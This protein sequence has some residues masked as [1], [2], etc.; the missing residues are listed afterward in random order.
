M[1]ILF[2]SNSYPE[3]LRNRLSANSKVG[4]NNAVNTFQSAFIK[5]L[6][7]NNANFEVLCFPSLGTF[8]I[9]YKKMRVSGGDYIFEG[10]KIGESISYCALPILKNISIRRKIYKLLKNKIVTTNETLVVVTYN[11]SSYIIE[12]LTKLKRQYPQLIICPIVTDLIDE[13]FNPIYHRSLLKRIQGKLEMKSI[14]NSYKYI[15]KFVLLSRSM[16]EKI[17]EAIG[18]SIVVEGIHLGKCYQYKKKDTELKTLLYTGALAAHACINELVDAF[19]MTSN[20]NYRLVICGSGELATY[21]NNKQKDDSRI[22]FKGLVSRD[23]AVYLQQNATA[24]INPRK[25]SISL[26]KYS[27]PSKTMEYLASGTPMIGYKLDGI[28]DEYDQYMYIV[29]GADTIDLAKTIDEVLSLNEIELQ[30]KAEK[31]SDFIQNNKNSK[32][33]VKKIIDF[34]EDKKI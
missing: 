12:P 14:Y 25:P 18:H 8:P 29:N 28:P 20:K 21:I 22:I 17:P 7:E 4:L 30:Q 13:F 1:K 31:A 26:T 23:D 9:N 2:L 10:E 3:N 27:F 16:Q 11:L 24:V 33:Q 5:G 34:L 32:I 6:I 15:D 19:M